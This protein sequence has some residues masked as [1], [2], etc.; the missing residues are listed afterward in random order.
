MGRDEQRQRCIYLQIES[1][2]SSHKLYNS[3]YAQ[4]HTI[5]SLSHKLDDIA[6]HVTATCVDHSFL[7]AFLPI[8]VLQNASNSLKITKNRCGICFN[9]TLVKLAC[10][11][12]IKM[13][14]THRTQ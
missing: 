2:P 11:A 10:C 12:E 5:L 3:G 14:N 1:D 6:N 8:K 7:G 4:I 9:F 13:L